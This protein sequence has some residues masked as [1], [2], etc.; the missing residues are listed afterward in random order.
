MRR[1]LTR[2]KDFSGHQGDATKLHGMSTAYG[3]VIHRMWICSP[4]ISMSI[5]MKALLGDQRNQPS[6]HHQL[7]SKEISF[8]YEH[9]EPERKKKK[10][11]KEKI[12]KEK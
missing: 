3:N 2:L 8:T 7:K 10:K 4:K 9:H 1:L 5:A 6:T 11:K 12:T